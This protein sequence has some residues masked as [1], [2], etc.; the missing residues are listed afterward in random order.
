MRKYVY[1]VQTLWQKDKGGILEKE[2][3]PF[4]NKIT[5]LNLFLQV[6]LTRKG[7]QRPSCTGQIGSRASDLSVQS[8]VNSVQCSP[9]LCKKVQFGAILCHT[10][11]KAAILCNRIE[12][13]WFARENCTP[14]LT[15]SFC[16]DEKRF[17][18]CCAKLCNAIQ[19]K[20]AV[21][22]LCKLVQ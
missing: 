4:S 7:R 6:S 18:H 5:F 8:H 3:S 9:K 11:Q 22:F 1:F 2:G 14:S 12:W 19:E 16:T 20:Q 17:T 15:P 13:Q 10:V 21:K